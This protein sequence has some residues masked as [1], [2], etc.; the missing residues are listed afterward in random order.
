MTCA[1]KVQTSGRK[2]EPSLNA[3]NAECLI[4]LL[5]NKKL[6]TVVA[7]LD[8]LRYNTQQRQLAYLL[9]SDPFMWHN[10]DHNLIDLRSIKAVR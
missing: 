5:T 6:G 4:Y 1:L 7:Y 8:M 10:R 3:W 9:H 2:W